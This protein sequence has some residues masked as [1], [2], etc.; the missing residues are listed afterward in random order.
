MAYCPFC[1]DTKPCKEIEEVVKAMETIKKRVDKLSGLSVIVVDVSGSMGQ[2]VSGKSQM[3]RIDAGAAMAM[4]ATE[5][6]EHVAI[7]A[8]AGN[9]HTRVHKTSVLKPR[10]GFGLTEEILNKASILGGGIFTRQCI[11]FIRRD[12]GDTTPERIIVFSDSQDC[13][14]PDAK[15]PKPFGKKNYIVDVSSEERG[16]NYDGVWTA[17]VNGW[18]EYFFT[19]IAA[20]EG[21]TLGSNTDESDN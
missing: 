20:L 13:D 6:C 11:E 3:R 10:R 4:L 14:L 7:Y 1:G 17:E 19:Y 18:S 9:D 15:I 12:I 2:P 8:T 5:L 16:V 21:M